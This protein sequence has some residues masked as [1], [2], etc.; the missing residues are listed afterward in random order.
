M[1]YYGISYGSYLGATYANLF[2]SK[3]RA[4]VLDGNI[5]PVQWATGTGGSA[6]VLS[7]FLRLGS[8][9]GTSAALTAFLT[10]CGQAPASSC[11]F[12]AGSPAATSA[13][14]ATLLDRLAS[15][16]VTLAGVINTEAVAVSTA[17]GGL[18]SAEPVPGLSAGWSNLATFLEDLWTLTSG[19]PAPATVPSL[20][21]DSALT[22]SGAQPDDSA[23]YSGLESGL[24]VICS[25]SPNPRDPA[26]YAAQ[27]A[28][29]SARSRVVGPDWTWPNE[30]CAQW[31]VLAKDRYTGPF[32]R[33]T[34]AP[35]L[36]VG[37]TVDPATPNQGSVAMSRDLADARLLTVDG[38]GHTEYANPSTC[39][40]TAEDSYFL[41]A[42]LPPPGTVCHQDTPPFA[43]DAWPAR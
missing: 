10:L 21:R 25:D 29:A 39:A 40:A 12:S 14:F 36:V 9:E 34:A 41:S 33:P 7:T 17:V 1:N 23:P 16:P 19:G 22:G 20:P 8:D 35:I 38:D 32:N 28:L 27:A 18:Y 2:P 5:D 6:A 13:R 3:V 43:G 30:A 37:N 11:V 26:G 4:M 42:T 15:H 24:G 31:P